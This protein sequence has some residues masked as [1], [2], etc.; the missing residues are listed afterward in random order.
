[1]AEGLGTRKE[2][3]EEEGISDDS[4]EVGVRCLAVEQLRAITRGKGTRTTGIVSK[5]LEE[6]MAIESCRERRAGV[7]GC[8]E[9]G[10]GGTA[11]LERWVDFCFRS[12]SSE[13][14]D[15]RDGY[16]KDVPSVS[17]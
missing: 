12:Y 3:R 5:K 8:K 2:K 11:V 1:L 17:L 4:K 16:T 13:E 7:D 15:Q 14:T 9:E 10:P 6:A